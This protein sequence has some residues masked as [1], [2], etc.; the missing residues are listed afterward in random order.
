LPSH[1]SLPPLKKVCWPALAFAHTISASD[2]PLVAYTTVY[3]L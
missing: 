2:A 1:Y 3:P